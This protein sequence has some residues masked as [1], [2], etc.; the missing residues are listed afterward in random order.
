MLQTLYF[1]R[2]GGLQVPF[3]SEYIL[4]PFD[5]DIYT[6]EEYKNCIKQKNFALPKRSW[7]KLLEEGSMHRRTFG[8]IL[9]QITTKENADNFLDYFDQILKRTN[10]F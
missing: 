9:R 7:K 10:F 2:Y 4:T 3:E 6:D 5:S 1:V 8:A